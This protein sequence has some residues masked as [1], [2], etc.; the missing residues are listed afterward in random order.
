MIR[1]LLRTLSLV[2]LL[3]VAL[4]ILAVTDTPSVLERTIEEQRMQYTFLRVLA[5]ARESHISGPDS[6]VEMW[7]GAINGLLQS[8]DR[9]S[10]YIS[11]S[12]MQKSAM[13][14]RET[15]SGIGARI[16][17]GDGYFELIAPL[18]PDA[19]MT[20]AGLK[21]GDIVIEICNRKTKD[22]EF[23][24]VPASVMTTSK[25]IELIKGKAG[26]VVRLRVRRGTHLD[27]YDVTRAKIE[28]PA[29]YA[30]TIGGDTVYVRLSDFSKNT[31]DEVQ[32]AFN[33]QQS[34]LPNKKARKMIFDLRFNPGGLLN[35]GIDIVDMFIVGGRIVTTIDSKGD[36]SSAINATPNQGV[37]DD[38]SVAVL[39]N[40]FSASASE[41]VA[42]SLQDYAISRSGKTIIVG[43]KSF[44]KGSV[45]HMRP[46][47]NGGAFKLTIAR[48]YTGSGKMI[49]GVGVI[50]DVTVSLKEG[51][52]IT[53][54][55]DGTI[56]KLD[57]QLAKAVAVLS[58][59][60]ATTD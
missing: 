14:K 55:L 41:I 5:E 20:K 17:A 2:V 24:C 37:P 10:G 26:S 52:L 1:N 49:D 50:P 35:E 36:V 42:G 57:T 4:P 19:P 28:I 6:D 18:V 30:G 53:S 29:V 51:E 47:P 54:V 44:G 60:S 13:M 9:H 15:L 40:N 16:R 32:E 33:V 12:S 43:E 38:V 3:A 45:Q 11:P 25:S 56:T 22:T 39:I 34:L 59:K 7:E 8:L 46:L 48:Y 21:A 27:F 58:E 31:A 23:V